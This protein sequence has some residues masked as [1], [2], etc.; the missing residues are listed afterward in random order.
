MSTI[1]WKGTADAVAQVS[2][3]QITAD[4]AATTY[5]VTIGGVEVSCSGAGT[6]VND[7]AS[8]LQAALDASTH[9]Y[10]TA[11][12]WTVAT[13]TV[14]GTAGTAGVPFVATSSV[15][16]GT[17]TIGA[18]TAST[19][20]S[21]PND[22]ST[23]DN[24]SGGAVPV[25]SDDV[26]IQDNDVNICWGLD[27]NSV[28]LTSLTIKK[29]YTGK[30]GLRY[31]EFAT[32]ADGDTRDSSKPEYRDT[33]LKIVSTS[34]DLGEH[35]GPGAPAGSTRIKL[36]LHTTASTVIVHG[37][38]NT[39][40]ETGLPAVRLKATHANTDVYVR[41]APGGVG[42]AVDVP[43]ETS[44]VRKISVSD[45]TTK[46]RVSCGAGTTLTTWEQ[47][48]GSN[49]LEAAGTVTT[50]ETN[51][52]TLQIEGSYTITAL[53]VNGGTVNDNHGG[54]PAVTTATLKGG[55]TDTQGSNQDRTYTTVNLWPGA[56]LQGDSDNLTITTLNES[57]GKY[58]LSASA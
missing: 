4:D 44:T 22:W 24:W 34:V 43:G 49:V 29:T 37:T 14:T 10:F 50:V 19:A 9:P 3:I 52:G 18:V 6:G 56:T 21:G 7:T 16:G 47:L 46:S 42:V 33:Y 5:K 48:G 27:Q 54:S 51:G 23:A 25:N 45:T 17:G 15:S 2:T 1:Y 41:S 20:S 39:S 40:A 12:T 31:T 26:I 32:S 30:I 36:D 55:V 28:A 13:D 58:T 35:F 38:A 53:N 8:A 57:G 11:I